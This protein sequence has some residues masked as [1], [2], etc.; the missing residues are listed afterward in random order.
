MD[1]NVHQPWEI[2]RSIGFYQ[3]ASQGAKLNQWEDLYPLAI[4]SQRG[5]K[6]KK[7][8]AFLRESTKEEQAQFLRIT[9]GQ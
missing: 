2:G 6:T 8:K 5:R 9:S 4:D 1:V 3:M 7:E